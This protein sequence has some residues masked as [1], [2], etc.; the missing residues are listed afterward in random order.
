MRFINATARETGADPVVGGPESD[1]VHT[2]ASKTIKDRRSRARLRTFRFT[3]ATI[4]LATAVVIPT[5][6]NY[7]PP[8]PLQAGAQLVFFPANEIVRRTILLTGGVIWSVLTGAPV[9]WRVVPRNAHMSAL[10]FLLGLS[11]VALVVAVVWGSIDRHRANYARLN[12]FTRVYARWVTAL[13]VL[14]YA[15]VKVVPTQFGFLTP[16]ELL[17]P[18]GQLSRF[19]VL[20]N[21]MAVSPAY[22]V[23]TGLVEVLG[24]VMLLFPRTTMVGAALL[25]LALGNVVAMDIAYDIRGAVLVAICLLLLNAFI[26][27]PYL[28]PLFEFVWHRRPTTLPDEAAVPIVRW[29]YSFPAKVA[30]LIALVVIRVDDGLRQRQSYFKGSRTIYGV[31]DVEI[32]NRNGETVTPLASDDRTWKR[33]ASDGRYGSSAGLT[34]QFSNGDVRQFPV[35]DDTARGVWTV[36]ENR[37]NYSATLQYQVLPDGGVSLDGHI[38]TDR[39]SLRLRP[40][41]TSKFPLLAN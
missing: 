7:F 8:G 24:A 31:F 1:R 38:G 32:F 16:G 2:A 30:L 33:V 20:W 18:F 36:R 19:S 6:R 5:L 11:A 41:D 29:R 39:V 35:M 26:L 10:V 40:V 28:R 27:I 25:F 15:L 23:F 3:F 14:Y 9:T 37:G 4:V 34:V 13:V 12:R 17:R 22:T 21:F